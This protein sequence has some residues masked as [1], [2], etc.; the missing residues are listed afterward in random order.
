MAENG[1]S[2]TTDGLNVYF[3]SHRAG[4][5][6]QLAFRLV[7]FIDATRESLDCAIYD[8]R[9]PE[10]LAAL[11]RVAASGKRLR[12]AFDASKE[13]T[14][15]LSGDPK[16]SGTHQA[17]EAAGLMDH[18]TP[19]HE[20]G[21]HL[22]HH[23]FLVRDG[24]D[25]WSGSANFTT[26]GLEQQDN[27]CYAVSS[28]EL[29]ASFTQV[30][31]SLLS[32]HE[33]QHHGFARALTATVGLARFTPIFEPAAGEGIEDMLVAALKSAHRV[34]VLAFLISDPGILQALAAFR[35]DPRADIRGVY[36]PHGMQDVLR[37]T[38][39]DHALFWF[40]Q[41]PRFVAAPSHA[42]DPAR[43][44]DFMHDKVLIIDDRIVVTGSYNFSENAEANDEN[45][46]AIESAEVAA[47]YT[48]YFDALYAAYGGQ[49]R[50]EAAAQTAHHDTRSIEEH[51]M[52]EVPAA[53]RAHVLWQSNWDG[54]GLD[55][56]TFA[57]ARGRFRGQ[58]E[59]GRTS[60]LVVFS[61][62]TAQ[63]DA[64]ARA[65]LASAQ[66]DYAAV[67]DWFGGIDL[68]RGQEGDDQTTPRTATPVQVLIDEQAGGAYHFGCSATD[69]YIQPVPQL[70][71]GFMVAELVENFEAAIG[72][73]WAC[74]NTN[75]E[76]LSRVLAAERSPALGADLG[77]T[78]QAW[79]ASGH[80][81]YV[82]SNAATDQ[83]ENSNGCATLFLYY[84]H[85]Q[86]GYSWQRIT[87]T[88]G[89]TLGECYQK[90]TGRDGAQGFSDFVAACSALDQ[91]GQL[92]LP[93]SGNPFPVGGAAQPSA[94]PDAPAVAAARGGARWAMLIAAV[95]LVVLVL[96]GVLFV[97]GYV[98]L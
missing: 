38:Q 1:T 94:S 55:E 12:I 90:L 59:V 26:G 31:E 73:G 60:E 63:G 2:F 42:F 36:D 28:P 18:A 39:Q 87:T 84:L 75:G 64:S 97:T 19:V 67:R 16:P 10:I 29:A 88:G 49:Q 6:A 47:A 14:G 24:H 69:L 74:G 17:L 56:F 21:R 61:D 20:T 81:D 27:N 83:D 13:R 44:Q 71:S 91:G 77:Q 23:K 82:N 58:T 98:H 9:H 25:I 43:E 48:A 85:S 3:Q 92:A 41:D 68:P 15:G 51:H 4:W 30:F 80:A 35:D 57:R 53:P 65:V 50:E 8:L 37:Y 89:G 46:M 93:Q 78:I 45:V 95:M 7:E 70:A 52:S 79:W 11:A 40:M 66:A 33:H 62:G 96:A 54:I 34:R 86:L 76:G 72:N 22:M 5:E 32:Q